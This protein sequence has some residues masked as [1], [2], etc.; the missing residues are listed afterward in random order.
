MQTVLISD[1]LLGQ[2]KTHGRQ[3]LNHQVSRDA[4]GPG[5]C[6]GHWQQPH[7]AGYT[8]TH[9]QECLPTKLVKRALPQPRPH[10]AFHKPSN[11]NLPRTLPRGLAYLPSEAK[12]AGLA[13]P[14]QRTT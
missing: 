8:E 2:T 11:K 5:L 6:R 12:T 10:S 1:L 14:W 9:E 7:P 4:L 3:L 13:N